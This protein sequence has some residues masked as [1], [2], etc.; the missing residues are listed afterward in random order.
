MSTPPHLLSLKW[1]TVM[2]QHAQLAAQVQAQAAVQAAHTPVEIIVKPS[3]SEMSEQPELISEY[4][5][6]EKA[7]KWQVLQLKRFA[8][9]KR[10]LELLDID[11]PCGYNLMFCPICQEY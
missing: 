4:E 2:D 9:L 6:L 11:C 5:L 10:K 8:N 1:A 3:M 7:Q